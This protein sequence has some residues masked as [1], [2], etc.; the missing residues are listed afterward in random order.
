MKTSVGIAAY[1]VFGFSVLAVA[2]F[3]MAGCGGQA[4]SKPGDKS[5][6]YD[7]KFWLPCDGE[8]FHAQRIYAEGSYWDITVLVDKV[9]NQEY[10]LI[11][12]PPAK[13]GWVCSEPG[14][15]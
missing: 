12:Y 8:R 3:V 7:D 15:S 10:V 13:D 6:K 11:N 14:Q 2:I 4:S 5:H 9:T 1:F